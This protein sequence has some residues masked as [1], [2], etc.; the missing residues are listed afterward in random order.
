MQ[1]YYRM[2]QFAAVMAFATGGGS[3]D[4]SFFVYNGEHL[5]VIIALH[6]Y[7]LLKGLVRLEWHMNVYG[8]SNDESP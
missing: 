6:L 3:D 7:C 2:E 4:V 8:I 1:V 5:F